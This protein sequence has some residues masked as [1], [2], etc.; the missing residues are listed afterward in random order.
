MRGSAGINQAVFG[1]SMNF[2]GCYVRGAFVRRYEGQ[3]GAMGIVGVWCLNEEGKDGGLCDV[4][5]FQ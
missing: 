5:V 1:D 4:N 2:W 3:V